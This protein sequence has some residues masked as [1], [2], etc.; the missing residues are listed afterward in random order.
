MSQNLDWLLFEG[1][2]FLP[3]L[4]SNSIQEIIEYNTKRRLSPGSA[5]AIEVIAIGIT[6]NQVHQN[7]FAE[8]QYTYNV[9]VE[10]IL[11]YLNG[12]TTSPTLIM[13]GYLLKHRNLK[14][15]IQIICSAGGSENLVQINSYKAR[16]MLTAGDIYLSLSGQ[17]PLRLAESVYDL[18]RKDPFSPDPYFLVGLEASQI[19]FQKLVAT[20]DFLKQPLPPTTPP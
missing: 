11:Q 19:T 13:G 8:L 9:N 17:P 20:L 4:L 18:C 1:S 3:P 12:F 2:P 16:H 10:N 7:T 6:L 14:E 5:V 15:A